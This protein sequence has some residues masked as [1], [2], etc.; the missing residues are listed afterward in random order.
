MTRPDWW[1]DEQL[2]AG[3]EHLDPVSVAGYDAKSQ[4]DPTLDIEALV[5][6]GIAG[7]HLLFL[8]TLVGS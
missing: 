7:L 8:T 4:V 1:L 3:A 5:A 6:L 2:H